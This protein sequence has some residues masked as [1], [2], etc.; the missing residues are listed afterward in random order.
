MDSNATSARPLLPWIEDLRASFDQEMSTIHDRPLGALPSV[1]V[2]LSLHFEGRA[3]ASHSPT[4][5]GAMAP[6]GAAAAGLWLDMDV[7]AMPEGFE[8]ALQA[9]G[10]R[11]HALGYRVPRGSWSRHGVPLPDKV[12]WTNMR[13]VI[14]ASGQEM[15]DWMGRASVERCARMQVQAQAQAAG[16]LE[17][18]ACDLGCDY[19]LV[20]DARGSGRELA[21]A[22]LKS[23]MASRATRSE[24]IQA[25]GGLGL[26]GAASPVRI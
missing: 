3:M 10:A 23:A 15:P 11:M 1:W 7:R 25:A 24:L 4:L 13:L 16:A 22:E 26:G 19:R 17:A 8:D 2:E 5:R 9:F 14:G 21:L 6:A 18:F 20:A 12:L